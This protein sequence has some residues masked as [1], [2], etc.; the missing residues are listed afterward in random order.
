MP[1][2]GYI[3]SAHWYNCWYAYSNSNNWPLTVKMIPFTITAN[4]RI[5]LSSLIWI[6]KSPIFNSLYYVMMCV[7]AQINCVKFDQIIIIISLPYCLLNFN[8]IIFYISQIDHSI[9]IDRFGHY[10]KLVVRFF[11]P[12]RIRLGER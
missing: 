2:L 1:N 9:S 6:Q 4:P 7:S 5:Q 8:S 3:I 11:K 12:S 10:V